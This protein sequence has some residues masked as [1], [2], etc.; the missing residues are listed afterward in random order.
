MTWRRE[1][2]Q[3]R[4]TCSCSGCVLNCRFMPGF[5]LPSDLGRMIPKNSDPFMWAESNLLASP[6]ALVMKDGHTFRIPT[7]VPAT[8]ADGSCIHLTSGANCAI[9]ENAPFGCAFFDCGPERAGLANKAMTVIFRELSGETSLYRE[10]WL[11]LNAKGL[12]QQ[13]CEKLR[14]RMLEEIKRGEIATE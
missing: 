5:L 4:T 12:N 1:F 9:H 6:G 3:E 10:I 7:L 14:I 11:H 2:G 8:K 13:P